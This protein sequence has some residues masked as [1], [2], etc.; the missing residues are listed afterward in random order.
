MDYDLTDIPEGYDRGRDHGLEFLELWMNRI[1]FHLDRPR[2][3]EIL[4]LGCGT[5]RFSEGLAEKFDATVIGVDPSRKM[6]ERA[7]SKKRDYRVQ[8]HHGQADSIPI[9]AHSVDVI[10]ISMSFH[11]FDDKTASVHECW[12]VLGKDGE[13]A[14]EQ[15]IG[16]EKESGD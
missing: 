15:Q 5:G 13:G 2:V 3:T 6:L 7:R 14:Q 10:F 4:D 11:H 8:Y 16:E 1:E 12:R 9:P